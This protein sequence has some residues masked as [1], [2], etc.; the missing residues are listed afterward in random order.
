MHQTLLKLLSFSSTFYASVHGVTQ[1]YYGSL[2][3]LGACETALQETPPVIEKA[4]ETLE[5][6]KLFIKKRQKLIKIA[7]RSEYGWAIIDEY[8]EDELAEGEEDDRH[9][10]RAERRAKRRLKD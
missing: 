6:G 5:E 4:R 9:L 3:V 10:F 2:L 1:T 8:V 7:D